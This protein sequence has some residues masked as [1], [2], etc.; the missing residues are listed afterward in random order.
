MRVAPGASVQRKMLSRSRLETAWAARRPVSARAWPIVRTWPRGRRRPCRASRGGR[1]R[2]GRR[3][4]GARGAGESWHGVGV[5]PGAFDRVRRAPQTRSFTR[6][7]PAARRR[8]APAHRI[9]DGLVIRS[10]GSWYNVR[11]DDGSTSG[12][13]PAAAS[14]WTRSTS[15]RPTRSRSATASAAWRTTTRPSYRHPARDNQLSRRAAGGRGAVREHVIVANVDM[16]WCVQSVY[17]PKF[18]PG[19]VD[20]F[21][22]AAEARHV[23]AGLVLN[24]ADLMAERAARAGGDGLLVRPLPRPGLPRAG[25]ERRDRRGRRRPPGRARDGHQRRLGP[26]GVGKSSLLNAVEPGLGL[27]TSHIGE[28]THKGRHTTTFATLYEAGGG[29]VV[30]TP[31]MREFGV[32]DMSPNELGGYFV[33][34]RPFIPD[35]RFPDCTHVHEP[36]CGVIDAVEAEARSPSSA[37]RATSASW[38]PSRPSTRRRARSAGAPSAART[39]RTRPSRTS[40]EPERETTVCVSRAAGF[41]RPWHRPRCGTSCPRPGASPRRRATRRAWTRR[42]GGRG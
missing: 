9:A 31:G 18:N 42:C 23:A 17:G 6:P 16:A 3:R 2:R 35:C 21:L 5:E 32:W 38:R 37:T 27:R 8:P 30:D 40:T 22:V 36:G 15:T 33:E 1:R 20:R 4:E 10:T 12:R 13:A 26:I 11:T 29:W 34:F 41:R 25:D 19:F 7:M 39:T 28:R 14:G 24:K